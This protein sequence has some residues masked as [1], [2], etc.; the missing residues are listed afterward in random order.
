MGRLDN[1]TDA[2]PT[3]CP[4]KMEQ[5]VR[6]RQDNRQLNA[7]DAIN[8]RGGPTGEEPQ[9]PQSEQPDHSMLDEQ[10]DPDTAR[11]DTGRLRTRRNP[12]VGGK[13]GTPDAGEPDRAG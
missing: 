2:T 5:A 11:P 10:P 3:C 7:G 4:D 13:G 6:H 8:R 1:N 12:R 9:Q